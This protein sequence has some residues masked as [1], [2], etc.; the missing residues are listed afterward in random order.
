[1]NIKAAS[2]VCMLTPNALRARCKDHVGEEVELPKMGRV[3]VTKVKG[4]YN[5]VYA[6]KAKKQQSR[7]DYIAAKGA[8]QYSAVRDIG[9]IPEVL[10]LERRKSCKKNLALFLST[11][12]PESFYLDWSDDHYKII[13][14]TETAIFYG[15]LFALAMPRGSG[16]T[17]L[18]EGAVLF[19]TLY[20][21]RKYVIPI[22]ANASSAEGM[23]ES[24]KSELESNELLLE[25]FPEVCFPFSQLE[26][27]SL[28]AKGQTYNNGLRTHIDFK[29]KK[30]IFPTIEGSYSSGT[31][32]FP[33][34]LTG[35]IRGLKH[36]NVAGEVVRPDFVLLDDPQDDE[37]AASPSQCDKRE[38]LINGA[39]LGLAGHKKKIAGIMPCTI[40]EKND[41]AARMLD[42][43][44]N[45]DWQGET[46]QMLYKWPDEQEG[47]W[48]KYGE[49]RKSS[50]LEGDRG[51]AATEFYKEHKEAMDK[52]AIVGWDK[53]KYDSEI[54]ALQHAENLLLER[55]ESAFYAEFQNDPIA[56]V[57]SLY[58]LTPDIVAGRTNN[59]NR[60]EI[61]KQTQFLVAGVDVNVNERGINF[62][63][64]AV[65]NDL[66][67]Y[68]VDYGRF[69]E[70]G[71]VWKNDN[72]SN[73]SES[74]AIFQALMNVFDLIIKQK[75]FMKDGEEKTLDGI[76]VD[77]GYMMSTVFQTCRAANSML[78]VPIMPSRGISGKHYRQTKPIGKPG[79]NFHKTEYAGKGNV[80]AFNSDTW[81]M[82]V[83]KAFLMATQSPG[84][85]SLWGKEP[86]EHQHYAENI[87]CE[88]L[89]EFV[90]G[91]IND[92]YT[93]SYRPGFVN[94]LL[95]ATIIAEIAAGFCGASNTGGEA[96]WRSK[97]RKVVKRRKGKVK[98][99]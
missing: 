41:L 9:P 36:K 79:E 85:I 52:G 26:G 90:K 35:N 5:I 91:D 71:A 94:D 27:V 58:E 83:Q 62:V 47:L 40:I 67:S 59:Y 32:I 46:C 95:D 68:V 2:I 65:C 37:S 80:I 97:P 16:K 56:S 30:I 49:I 84:S 4:K 11:Y 38:K 53:R 15:G 72:V 33:K 31:I 98:Y 19:A 99:Y 60:M 70:V 8:E 61:P 48:K 3:K 34:G 55:G 23:L 43:T 81:K 51:K 12:M 21:H 10:N 29:A 20:G 75:T 64:M 86:K 76:L 73:K 57:V 22:G 25:D 13:K 45:P 69:P 6:E 7:R 42:K 77:C 93:W 28:R 74:Q 96:S 17:T 88:V 63:I 87:C 1:M 44:R 66:T 78:P 92:H 54:S 24:I 89:S 50:I 82:H 18:V 14:K 39:V